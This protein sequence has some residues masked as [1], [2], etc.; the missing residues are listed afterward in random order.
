MVDICESYHLKSASFYV[1][2]VYICLQE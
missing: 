1:H 2:S